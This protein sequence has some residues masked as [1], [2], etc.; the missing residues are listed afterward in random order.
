MSGH[1]RQRGKKGQWYA[2]IDVTKDGKRKRHW[3][4]LEGT[5][6]GKREAQ[7]ACERLIAQQDEGTYVD[8]S[9]M[10]VGPASFDLASINGRP[11][12]TSRPERPSA[13]ANS[14]RT[15][16]RRISAPSRSRS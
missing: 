9:K 3:Q 14:P 16:S 2:V 4:R 7:K 10:P 13:T 1:V 6:S 8:P 5:H 11:L 12:T 15:K